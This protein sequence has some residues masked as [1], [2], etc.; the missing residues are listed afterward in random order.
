MPLSR[1]FLQKNNNVISLYN[2]S[3]YDLWNI[4]SARDSSFD[5]LN[6]HVV[7]LF[8]NFVEIFNHHPDGF[9][10]RHSK[11]CLA[12]SFASDK[13][14][15]TKFLDVMRN[16]GKRNINIT[17]NITYGRLVIFIEHC[18]RPAKPDIFKNSQTGFIG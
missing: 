7:L 16:R 11:N 6:K 3:I 9:I 10:Y 1:I 15:I 12:P 17:G 13:S 14:G 8:Y 4:K 18:L 5:P 2:L